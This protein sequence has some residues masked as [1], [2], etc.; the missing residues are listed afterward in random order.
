MEA[1]LLNSL[2]ADCA[3]AFAFCALMMSLAAVSRHPALVG[4]VRY[5]LGHIGFAAGS[6]LFILTLDPEPDAARRVLLGWIGL[7]ASTVG[8][9]AMIDGLARLLEHPARPAIAATAWAMAAGLL[10]LGAIP[11]G[12]ADSRRLASDVT[13]ALVMVGMAAV[14]LRRQAAPHRVP[15]VTAGA[16]AAVLG[17]LYLLGAV[18]GWTGWA[19]GPLPAYADWVWLDLALW[20]TINLCVMMLASFRALVLFV[21][22][23]HTD[24]LT[25]CLNRAGFED[26]VRRLAIRL[27]KQTPVVVLALDIDHFKAIN[28]AHGHGAGDAY[29]AR[30]AQALQGCVRQSDLVARVGGEEFIAV[31]VDAQPEAGQRVATKILQAVR[32]LQVPSEGGPVGTTVSIGIAAGHGLDAV[33][34]LQR[35]ADLALYEAKGAGRDRMAVALSR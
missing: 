21:R 32:D 22:R 29:L 7:G 3:V 17:L 19:N 4:G 8:A 2:I 23:S 12:E 10:V 27:P 11:V 26:E 1:D 28:D 31:L 25:H 34:T 6:S 16:I 30:F 14:L 24:P 33:A 35:E 13:N 5:A 18:Q 15:A 20:D 9:A